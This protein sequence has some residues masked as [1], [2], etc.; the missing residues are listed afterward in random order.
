VAIVLALASALCWGA[1][2]FI[3]GLLTR[4]MPLSAVLALGQGTSLV[5]IGV[6]ALVVGPP[7]LSP[8]DALLAAA[9]GGCV[10]GALACFYRALARGTVSVVAPITA[11]GAGLPVAVG[12]LTGDALTPLTALGF[13]AVPFGVAMAAMER[14]KDGGRTVVDVRT[15]ALAVA[16]GLLFGAFYIVVESPANASFVS[17]LLFARLA[18]TVLAATALARLRP[19]LPRGRTALTACTV[20]LGD[21]CGMA[22]VVLASSE[23]SLSLVS[24]L[25]STYP[26][27]TVVLAVV[28]LG[29]R[30][31]GRQYGGVALTL[32]GVGLLTAG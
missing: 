29:E 17:T 13:V 5:T 21:M 23:G 4:R 10:V 28:V 27:V 6:I 26:L 3:G 19:S 24:A 8:G 9:S 20:G 15:I 1:N 31:V 7:A 2:D 12:L 18:S 22:L 14:G 25:S 30:P 16:A 11:S 32:I